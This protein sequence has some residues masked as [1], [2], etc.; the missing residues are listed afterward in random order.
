MSLHHD[1]NVENF[2]Q[3]AKNAKDYDRSIGKPCIFAHVTDLKVDSCGIVTRRNHRKS[4][5]LQ[6]FACL[7]AIVMHFFVPFTLFE[8]N[9]REIQVSS[10]ITASRHSHLED[11]VNFVNAG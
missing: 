7:I 8:L 9:S 1:L 10:Q 3:T 5:E 11:G 2:G 6:L 4:K